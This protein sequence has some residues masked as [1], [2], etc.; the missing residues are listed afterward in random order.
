MFSC[1]RLLGVSSRDRED[2]PVQSSSTKTVH[3]TVS[4]VGREGDYIVL[5]MNTCF[6]RYAY[7]QLV[8]I[9]SHSLFSK[10]FSEVA[11]GEV[12]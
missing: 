8:E 2:I 11:N 6:I 5:C 3:Q 4:Q 1:L 9:N 7:G 10:W 12:A